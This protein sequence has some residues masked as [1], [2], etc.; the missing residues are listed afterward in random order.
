[1]AIRT[2]AIFYRRGIPNSYNNF[3]FV[4]QT[5]NTVVVPISSY[6]KGFKF[7]NRNVINNNIRPGGLYPWK[8]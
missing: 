5:N 2:S 6:L 3:A 8:K 7:Y 1:M 4:S